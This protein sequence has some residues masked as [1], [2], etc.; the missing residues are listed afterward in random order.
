[1]VSVVLRWTSVVFNGLRG[2]PLSPVV[3]GGLRRYPVDSG[4]L[5]RSSMVS[6]GLRS[7][8]GSPKDSVGLRSLQ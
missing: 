2:S 3:S 7:L 5:Q 6:M 8:R 1:M 4:V